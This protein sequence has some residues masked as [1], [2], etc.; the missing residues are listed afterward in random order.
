ML[1]VDESAAPAALQAVRDAAGDDSKVSFTQVD[2]SKE[3]EV[4][5]IF[6]SSFSEQAP[7]HVLVNNAARFVFG[8]VTD[9]TEQQWDQALNTNVKGYAWAMKYGLQAMRRNGGTAVAGGGGAIV[10]LASG[11]SSFIAQPAFVP[12]STTKG[13]IMQM[14]RCAA[15]DSAK[16]GVRVN[17]VCPGPILTE[18]TARHA[19][20]L[21][22]SVEQACQEMTRNQILPR[23]GTCDEVAAAVAF[24]A[25]DESA[26]TTGTHLIIDGGYTAV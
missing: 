1:D 13:A 25:S 2:M 19:K 12:Y 23:M 24:L 16:W 14:T 8:E 5:E 15:L 11:C 26:F 17:A 3:A 22:V 10:N 20:M 4:R 18:G 6:E 21:G 7:L 9:V